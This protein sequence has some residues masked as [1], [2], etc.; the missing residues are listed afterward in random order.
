MELFRRRIRSSRGS[1]KNQPAKEAPLKNYLSA[2]TIA[3]LLS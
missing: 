3:L 2:R 1:Q